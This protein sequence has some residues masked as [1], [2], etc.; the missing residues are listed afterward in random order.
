MLLCVLT[1]VAEFLSVLV[2]SSVLSLGRVGIPVMCKGCNFWVLSL[3]GT[4]LDALACLYQAQVYFFEIYLYCSTNRALTCTGSSAHKFQTHCI[5]QYQI[6]TT[7]HEVY[8][9]DHIIFSRVL[10]Y[11]DP[12]PA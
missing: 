4:L 9:I 7:K 5:Y 3:T 2:F 11:I 1:L 10:C 6:T 12:K 8:Q